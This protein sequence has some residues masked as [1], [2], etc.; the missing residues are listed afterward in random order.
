[1][2]V[3]EAHEEVAIAIAEAEINRLSLAEYTKEDAVSSFF[4]S[5]FKV[6]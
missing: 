6:V 4:L 5:L 3:I 1:M 2:I